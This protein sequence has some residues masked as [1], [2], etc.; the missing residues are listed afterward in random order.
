M[1]YRDGTKFEV[2]L[3]DGQGKAFANK[4]VT[5]NVNG[6]YY[7]RTTDENGIARLNINLMPAQYIITSMYETA[8]TSNTI[9][10]YQWGLISSFLIFLVRIAYQMRH[11]FQLM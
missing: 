6:V 7:D 5:F 3:L 4:V 2:K 10:I 9:T 1:R 8:S 11:C